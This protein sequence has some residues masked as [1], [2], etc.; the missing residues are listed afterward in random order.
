[1]KKYA[2]E[3]PEELV[4]REFDAIWRQAEAELKA[5]GRTLADEGT[6]EE[7][8][9]ATYRKIAERRVRLGLALAE[10]GDSAGVKVSDEEVAQALYERAR[11]YPGMEKQFIDFYRN[12]AE[13]LAEI[14][15]PLFEEKVIDYV[16]GQ[17]KVTDRHVSKD[18]LATLV[19]EAE[20]AAEEEAQKNLGAVG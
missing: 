19:E 2:F 6:T 18:E 3:L 1:D 11:Q 8:E 10:I 12:N 17:S 9:R 16:L 13:R 14:R 5:S 15:G 4:A 20:K 7:Q